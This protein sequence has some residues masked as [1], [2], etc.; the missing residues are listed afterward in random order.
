MPVFRRRRLS[1]IQPIGLSRF[2]SLR[3][4]SFVRPPSVGIRCQGPCFFVSGSAGVGCRLVVRSQLVLTA[5]VRVV[6]GA[7]LGR[8]THLTETSYQWCGEATTCTAAPETEL[9]VALGGLGN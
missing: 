2:T 7:R 1:K 4:A 8:W 5:M 3:C 9:V 6:L